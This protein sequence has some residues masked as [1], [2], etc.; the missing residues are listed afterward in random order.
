MALS[1]LIFY[2]DAQIIFTAFLLTAGMTL[3][4]TA[5]AFTTKKDLTMSSA[6]GLMGLAN[7]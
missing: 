3:T 7:L 2:V 1:G 4:L 6:A 5:Y